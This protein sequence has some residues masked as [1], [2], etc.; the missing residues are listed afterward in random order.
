M[1]SKSSLIQTHT[2]ICT[3]K[4]LIDGHLCHFFISFA[5]IKHEANIFLRCFNQALLK[6]IPT[7]ASIGPKQLL[8]NV[9]LAES[10][11]LN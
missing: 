11:D 10:A 1:E 3:H 5:G 9:R 2:H 4:I 8:M 7:A 6:F